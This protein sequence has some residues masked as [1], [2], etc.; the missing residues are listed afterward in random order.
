MENIQEHNKNNPEN[1]K[2][3]PALSFFD[4]IIDWNTSLTSR[5][6]LEKL[7]HEGRRLR[8]KFGADITAQ[9]LHLGHAVNLRAM[10]SLQDLGHKVVFLLGGFTTMVGDPT[11]RLTT[12]SEQAEKDIEMNKKNFIDQVK[13]VLRFDDPELLEIRDNTEWWGNPEMHGTVTLGN[14]FKILGKV[15]HSQLIARDMF[16]KR[17]D[18]D[19]PILMSEFLY[20]IL[21]GY[22]SVELESDI[23]VVG[24]DQMFNEKMA[25]VFQEA[26]GQRKQAVL[27][28][29]I[30]LGLDGKNKQSKSIGN[31]VG[32]S[33]SSQEKFNRA[34]LLPD[35]LINEWFEVYT[36]APKEELEKCKL[37]WE[38][39][40]LA[41]KQRL[42]WYIVEQFH[43]KEAADSARIEYIEKQ[44]KMILPSDVPEIILPSETDTTLVRALIIATKQPSSV[45]RDAIKNN[46]VKIVNLNADSSY[47]L[48]DIPEK[49]P[50][51]KISDGT[52][53]KFGRNKWF[54]FKTVLN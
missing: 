3:E 30:T 36:R 35:N 40:P 48:T 13:T 25:W 26:A 17:I 46:A 29:K 11:G 52:I 21:Q 39:D 53:L 27:C 44:Q 37:E 4:R 38:K 20:P 28:T 32:L 14:F 23:T 31:Y 1:E 49:N 15:T 10:R 50:T 22:D 19:K 8:I 2:I 45:I 41:Y 16:Q 51:I 12:R 6:D 42:A 34:M 9:T 24:S 43:G 7:L 33:H 54:K 47:Q 5:E 18:E